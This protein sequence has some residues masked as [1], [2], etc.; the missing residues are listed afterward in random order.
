MKQTFEKKFNDVVFE[1]FQDPNFFVLDVLI[2]NVSSVRRKNICV[3]IDSERAPGSAALLSDEAG[4]EMFKFTPDY[5][6]Y[7]KLKDS[8][9]SH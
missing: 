1:N 2:S 6:S 7:G 8:D 9:S 3:L 4:R 5:R